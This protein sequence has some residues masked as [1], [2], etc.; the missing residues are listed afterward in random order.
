MAVA[1]DPALESSCPTW[2]NMKL[3]LRRSGT[4]GI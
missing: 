1:C 2:S 3:R 4:G